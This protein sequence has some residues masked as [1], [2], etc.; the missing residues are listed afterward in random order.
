[1]T[2]GAWC[3]V[4]VAFDGMSI[5]L[6]VD[7]SVSQAPTLGTATNTTHPIL[8][9]LGGGGQQL[10]GQMQ[11]FIVFCGVLTASDVASLVSTPTVVPSSITTPDAILL[12]YDTTLGYTY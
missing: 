4:M 1:V 11:G 5:W 6:Y 7:G 12:K 2:A 9:S 10:L 3:H 8:G